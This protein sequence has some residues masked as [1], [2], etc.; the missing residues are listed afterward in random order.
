VHERLVDPG[1]GGDVLHA[2]AARPLADEDG[3][4]GVEDASLGV[5]VL[6]GR[7][8]DGARQRTLLVRRSGMLT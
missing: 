6:G 5:A 7:R 1:L 4:R 2:G 8:P 3:A